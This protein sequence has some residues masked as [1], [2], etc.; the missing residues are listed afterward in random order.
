M[1][2]NLTTLLVIFT[3]LISIPAFGN[4]EWINRGRHFPYLESRNNEYYRWLTSGFLHGGWI[5]L[6][7]NMFVLWQFGTIVEYYYNELFGNTTGPWLYL[8]IYLLTIVLANIPTY[9]KHRDNSSY[10]SIGA[11]GA[12]SGIVVI[13]ILF[14]PWQMLYLY[15]IIPIPGILAGIGYLWYSSWASK[16]M[17]GNIDH[18]AH[19]YGAIFGMVFTIALKP[20]IFTAFLERLVS[21]FPF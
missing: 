1:E 11:S 21:D 10:S 17:E 3:C 19:F 12:V 7:I 16:N 8:L 4:P 2:L 20:G 9:I 18:D 15:G 5:H 14:Q 6:L 13:Y